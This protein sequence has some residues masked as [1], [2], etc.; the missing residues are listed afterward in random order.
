MEQIIALDEFAR[1]TLKGLSSENK[2]LF[3]KY[4]YDKKGSEI[5]QD[6]M[7]MPE[8]Y[9][10]DC[11]MEI[12][13]T[14]KEQILSEFKNGGAHFDLL[15]LGAGD[16]LKT[17]VLLSHFVN[18]Q[19]D[20]TYSPIDISISAVTNLVEDL[21]YDIPGL[22]VNGLSGDYF[23]MLGS[24]NN[25]GN[26]RKVALFL[27]S[28]IGNFNDAQAV[29]FLVKLRNSLKD[30]DQVFIGFDLKKKE[31]IILE[32]YND[33]A[34]HTAAFNLN[35]LVRIN[36]EL[37]ADF[38]IDNFY[39]QELYDNFSGKAE[40]FLISKIPQEVHIKMLDKTFSFRKDEKI[41]TEM[42]QKYD[43]QMIE[44]LADKTGFQIV[45]NYVDKR[46]YFMN[47][48]WKLKS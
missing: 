12:F 19:I 5:F 42:S 40:S 10:T 8:Y 18:Q 43:L 9:L 20:F 44:S 3:S 37:G 36:R 47:S 13:Q 33:K 14:Q 17:K 34:G 30:S 7:R 46:Q 21:R 27:G 39:H 31:N 22:Q 29:D 25:N 24:F 11:E 23:K 16:G 15:E 1:D 45:R 35:L 26:L 4:F 28:N 32:A 38:N 48:L 2:Y 41:Y 6:I